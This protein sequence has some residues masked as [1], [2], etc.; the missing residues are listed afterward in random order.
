[1]AVE[2]ALIVGGAVGQVGNPDYEMVDVDLGAGVDRAGFEHAVAASGA[3]ARC[4]RPTGRSG[5]RLYLLEISRHGRGDGGPGDGGPRDGGAVCADDRHEFDRR[6]VAGASII[7]VPPGGEAL[8]RFSQFVAT[9]ALPIPAAGVAPRP[10]VATAPSTNPAAG[11]GLGPSVTT[12]PLTGAAAGAGPGPSVTPA[13]ST[14]P[15]AGAGL[16]L[17]ATTAPLTSAAAGAGLGRAIGPAPSAPVGVPLTPSL[18]A[19]VSPL[20]STVTSAPLGSV[21]TRVLGR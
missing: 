15:A 13:P 5:D 14:S 6:D 18:S 2:T 8:A 16:G 4:V 19:G 17:S 12:A 21:V 1:V 9:A 7:V 10:S 20:I 3:V 11:A